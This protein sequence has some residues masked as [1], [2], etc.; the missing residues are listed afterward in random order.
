MGAR[1]Y[2]GKRLGFLGDGYTPAGLVGEPVVTFK[3]GWGGQGARNLP[4]AVQSLLKA[5]SDLQADDTFKAAQNAAA[6]PADQGVGQ[7]AQEVAAQEAA[8]A[9]VIADAIADSVFRT[10]VTQMLR[11]AATD[12]LRGIST[13]STGFIFELTLPLTRRFTLRGGLIRL[14][15]IKEYSG[16]VTY[17]MKKVEAGA[18]GT[19][20]D[21][22]LRSFIVS[23]D[24]AY[25][26]GLSQRSFQLDVT[27][28]VSM[29]Y[30]ISAGF[31][32]DFSE[33]SRFGF[34]LRGYF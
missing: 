21:G 25:D 13:R 22:A 5:R 3:V 7:P 6:Q 8:A 27:Y 12:S 19:N 15:N 10:G 26:T 9:Q 20:P 32:S 11:G 14:G 30:T 1:F 33:Y 16:G 4:V 17:Y 31:L 34:S 18:E 29:H 28:P 2:P 24:G 23:L